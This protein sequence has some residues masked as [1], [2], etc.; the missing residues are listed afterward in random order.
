MALEPTALRTV[1][2]FY[3][4]TQQQLAARAA[5]D[6]WRLSRIER[7]IAQPTRDEQRRLIESLPLLQRALAEARRRAS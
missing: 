4:L 5:I 3:N 2:R 6:F 7:G 1:R